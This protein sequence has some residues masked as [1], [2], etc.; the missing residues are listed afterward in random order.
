MN[1]IIKISPTEDVFS[2]SWIMH[3]RCNYDCMYCPPSRH[4]DTDPLP[5]LEELKTHW[6]QIFDKTHQLKKPYKLSIS[7]GEPT[8]NKNVLPFIAHLRQDFAEHI[9]HINFITNG[10][11][12]KQYY[13]RLCKLVDSLS[14][15]THTEFMDVEKFLD[16]IQA[17]SDDMKNNNKSCHVNIMDEFW[18]SDTVKTISAF[19]QDNQI[20]YTVSPIDYSFQTRTYPLLRHD[21][22]TA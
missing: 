14:F 7:G 17:C 13:L 2:I 4:N 12:S 20:N 3:I 11:A 5:S 1:Q 6:Q 10:S 22:I 19:C 16:N 8:I 21:K 18:A 15:S 9:H